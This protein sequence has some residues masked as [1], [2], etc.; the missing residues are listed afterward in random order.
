M[1]QMFYNVQST[2]KPYEKDSSVGSFEDMPPF[3]GTITYDDIYQGLTDIID[4]VKFSHMLEN[5]KTTHTDNVIIEEDIYGQSAGKNL[6]DWLVSG[7]IGGGRLVYV[8]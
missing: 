7:D 4:L 2:S 6:F 5:P 1:A 8:S 3:T